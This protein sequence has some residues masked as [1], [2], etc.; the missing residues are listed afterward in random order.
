VEAGPHTATFTLEGHVDQSITF[1]VLTRDPLSPLKA[2]LLEIP[3]GQIL[4]DCEIRGAEAFLDGKPAGKTPVVCRPVPRGPHRVRVLGV[5]R[6]LHVEPGEQSVFFSLKDAGM[7]RVPEGE[8]AF[9]VP[10]PNLGELPVRLEKT[11]AFYVDR[12]EVTNEQY[13]LFYAWITETRD[14]SRCDPSEGPRDHKPAFWGDPAHAVFNR[15]N[16][17]V[18]GVTWY[19][20]FA[21]AAWAGKRLPAEREWEKAARGTTRS[22]YPWGNDWN[23]EGEKRCN[24]A[25]RGQIDGWEF[26]SPVGACGGASPFGCLDM[27]GNVREWCADD[28]SPKKGYRVVRGG[29]YLG[30]EWNTTTAREPEAPFHNSTSL[31][32]RCVLTEKK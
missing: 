16:H 5:E 12:T 9:G 1:E 20:A 32:F 7:V 27:V 17:P 15:P 25:D 21:Y 18:V 30:K 11:G 3:P 24:W 26:T 14:H 29:S 19:D 22:I 8:F 2:K 31:G 23:P 4:V 13:A 10:N 6:L 28:F